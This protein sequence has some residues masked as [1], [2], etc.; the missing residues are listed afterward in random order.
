MDPFQ[1]VLAEP[2]SIAA[3]KALAA[4]WRAQNDPRAEL[5]EKQLALRDLHLNK[6][7]ASPRARQLDADVKAL[8]G[9]HGRA[10]AGRVADLVD[11]YEFKRG[12]V[13]EVTVSGAKFP[14]IASELFKLAP[15]QHLKITSPLGSLEKVLA[16]PEVR[17]L[18][19]IDFARMGTE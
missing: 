2:G 18:V 11:R 8:I 3:R 10:F 13:A 14:A 7:Y 19:S 5:V 15:I 6:D 4:H 12:L 9:N 16:V 17:K 1:R